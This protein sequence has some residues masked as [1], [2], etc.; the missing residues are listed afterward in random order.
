MKKIGRCS[1]TRFVVVQNRAHFV[2][3]EKCVPEAK[4]LD[5]P[6]SPEQ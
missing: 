2:R 1:F 4:K 5:K 6:V 3:T